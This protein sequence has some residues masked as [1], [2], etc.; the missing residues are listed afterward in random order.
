VL[1]GAAINLASVDRIR[2]EIRALKSAGDAE[3]FHQW[4]ALMIR[5]EAR[6]KMHRA[7]MQS[8]GLTPVDRARVSAIDKGEEEDNPWERF[9]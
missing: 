4:S 9:V 5:E 6:S 3:N 2:T 8:L 1:S 7:Y